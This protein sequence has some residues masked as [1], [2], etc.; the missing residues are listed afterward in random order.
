M[1]SREM[2]NS[3]LNN[4]AK[5]VH[6]MRNTTDWTA[7]HMISKKDPSLGM[8]IFSQPPKTAGTANSFHA[9]KEKSAKLR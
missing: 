2:K 5:T 8:K 3:S 1:K 7:L 4:I 6:H 9:W